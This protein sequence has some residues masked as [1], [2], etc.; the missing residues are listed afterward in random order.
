MTEPVVSVEG[1]AQSYGSPYLVKN[2]DAGAAEVELVEDGGRFQIRAVPA[3]PQSRTLV[4]VDGVR[5]GE[6]SLYQLLDDGRVVRGVAGAH[7]CGAV[8]AAPASPAL[9]AET[10]LS[11][12]VIW[13][14]GRTGDLPAVAGGWSW[15]SHSVAGDDPQA[16]LDEL[17]QRM[18]NAEGRLAASLCAAGRLVV[19]DGPLD[20]A[21]RR[22]R[23]IVGYVKTHRRALLEPALHVQVPRLRA[24]ERTSMFRIGDERYSCYA[25][26]VDA[27]PA[28]GPWSGIVRLEFPASAG[29]DAAAHAFD[30]LTA[31]LP[32]FAG[33][34]HRDPRAPQNLQPIGALEWRLRHL[35]GPAPLAERAV[36][37]AIHALHARAAAAHPMPGPTE[38]LA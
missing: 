12:L 30:E 3:L 19:A 7:A 37:D 9:F 36:R 34:P 28:H 8:I 2:E 17:Q 4:F 21:L 14:C 32:R 38:A 20:F 5:R 6:A 26:L 11:R 24:R 27:E 1:W 31:Q 25:R 29:L 16:P 15:E 23:E 10:R 22:D 33:V 35:L 13:G 18:R